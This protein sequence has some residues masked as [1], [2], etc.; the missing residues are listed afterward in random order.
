MALLHVLFVN[1]DLYDI[2]ERYECLLAQTSVTTT[3]DDV[4]T[5]REMTFVN[6]QLV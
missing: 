2:R 1:M 6:I 5:Y 3:F 4:S